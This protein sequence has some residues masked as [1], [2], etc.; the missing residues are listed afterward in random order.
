[1]VLVCAGGFFRQQRL[2][3]RIKTQ[4]LSEQKLSRANKALQEQSLLWVL[5]TTGCYLLTQEP[6]L[7]LWLFFPL[8]SGLCVWIHG[9]RAAFG[10]FTGLVILAATLLL[11]MPPHAL[12]WDSAMP[13]LVMLATGVY[14][15]C[16]WQISLTRHD[17]LLEQ[18]Q[19]QATTDALTGLINRRQLNHQLT[20]EMARARRHESPLSLVMFDIDHFKQLNDQFGHQTGDRVLKELGLLIQQN[21]REHDISARYGGEEFALILPETRL[22]HALELM[23]RLRMLIAQTVFCLPDQPLALTIS[24]GITAFKPEEDLIFNLIQRADVALYAAKHNGRN[25]VVCG[26]EALQEQAYVV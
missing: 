3:Q 7:C 1:L 18:L 25:C 26:Y 19:A 11:L 9:W 10:W 20:M 22:E 12:G 6:V 17:E 14:G 15:L 24:I 16:Q 13:M 2:C 21:V 5:A 8:Y 4:T 23:E